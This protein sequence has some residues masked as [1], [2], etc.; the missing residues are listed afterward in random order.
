MSAFSGILRDSLIE[1]SEKSPGDIPAGKVKTWLR[2]KMLTGKS[3]ASPQTRRRKKELPA[4]P[5]GQAVI[6]DDERFA[7]GAMT[8]AMQ[9][10][11]NWLIARGHIHRD[12][13]PIHTSTKAKKRYFIHT[14]PVHPGGNE[15][16][17]PQPLEEGLFLEAH[18]GNP[19]NKQRA[20]R[21]MAEYGYREDIL[22]FI[23]FD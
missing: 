11:A 13:C 5:E 18:A 17:S 21:L 22:Q 8:E 4:T 12:K 20:C 1:W 16:L 6:I 7:V 23:G 10:V 2:N 3:P 14:S 9:C 15:F 19:Q